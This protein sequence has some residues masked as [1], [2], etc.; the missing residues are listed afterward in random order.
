[1]I[2]RMN[3]KKVIGIV[4]VCLIAVFAITSI[5]RTNYKAYFS[6]DA[7]YYQDK[8]I[9]ATTNS[10]NLEVFKLNGSY[11]ER[12]I[13]F[14]APNSPLDKTDDFS[15]VK[16]NVENGHLF[17][18]AT[19]AYTLYKYDISNL[20][21]PI[22]SAKQKNTY[23]EWYERVDKFGPYMATVSKNS[24]KI[25]KIDTDTL[26][27]IDSFKLDSDLP[28]SVRF[29]AAGRYIT[30]VN[31]DNFVRIY[32]T[33]TRTVIASFPIN[34]RDS[35][36]LRKTYFDP[37]AKELYVFDD[38]FLK[39]FDLQGNLLISYPNSAANGY[40][41]EPA[42]D[43]NYVYA[44]NGD[45]VMK[46]A[47][48]NLKSGL[49]ISA[50]RLNN[51]GYAMDIKYVNTDEGDKLVVFNGGGIAVLNSSLK[52]I[53]SIQASE[54]PDQPQ[55]KE[56]LALAFDHYVGTP[57]AIV[58]LSGIG[59]LPGEDLTI[60]FGSQITNIKADANGRFSRV[61]TVPDV[62]ETHSQ[63]IDAKVTG[64]TSNQ[65]YSTSFTVVKGK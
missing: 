64:L 35:K 29:D 12:D 43:S 51:N 13:K 41:V 40:S 25:W 4:A 26:D 37:S 55:I 63:A 14:K 15:S 16:L 38:Y 49:K 58:T 53:A 30:S 34:Y 61:L 45:S 42:G 5:G 28:G 6:G 1:M 2:K 3:L 47:K 8:V 57:G 20:S 44:V 32:D 10:G 22:L 18:Y 59:Y 9:I 65:T 36:D 48:D 23:Y 11:L 27:V 56:N 62:P 21:N 54:I 46:L 39:R 33:K 24:V 50:N 17:A 52:K 60:N 31:K 19:S 7:T